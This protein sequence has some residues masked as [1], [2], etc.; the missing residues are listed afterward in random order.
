MDDA[1][2]DMT[3][4]GFS[5]DD[6]RTEI[7]DNDILDIIVVSRTLRLKKTESVQTNPSWYP[8]RKL[9]TI[10]MISLLTNTK[11]L[12]MLRQRVSADI[13]DYGKYQRNREADSGG[14]G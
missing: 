14:D 12:N 8:R 11:K 3:A 7:K 2:T 9:R 1:I 4:D 6:K 5:L 10:T 13:R